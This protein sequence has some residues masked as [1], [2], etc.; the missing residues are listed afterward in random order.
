[1]EKF[2]KANPTKE[3]F[4]EMMT[5]DIE[6]EKAI[7][8][9]IDNCIDG[10]KQT[11]TL[12]DKKI[13]IN[14]SREKFSLYDNCGGF[15]VETAREYAFNFGRVSNKSKT[16]NQVDYSVG[17]FGIGMKRTL[18]KIG[19]NIKVESQTSN[20][21]FNVT[22]DIEDWKQKDEDWTFDMNVFEVD[23]ENM[24]TG[25]RIDVENLNE[26]IA[27]SFDE[28]NLANS[29]LLKQIGYSYA[30]VMKEGMEIYV[31]GELVP[32]KNL[33][34][35]VDDEIQPSCETFE[36]DGIEVKIIA[37][38][39]KSS[40]SEAG[41]YIYG[42]D[43]LLLMADKTNV[44]GWKDRTGGIPQYHATYAMFRGVVFMKAKD[45]NKLPLT[46]TKVGVDVDSQSYKTILYHMQLAMQP[47]FQFLSK[48]ED[49]EMRT[50]LYEDYEKISIL[51]VYKTFTREINYEFVTTIKLNEMEIDT[52]SVIRYKIS[53]KD[54]E[55]VKDRL[56]EKEIIIK[57]N[58]QLGEH[59]FK[60]FMNMEGI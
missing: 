50:E 43:R 14:I 60:Y 40:P 36:I 16:N 37:G 11:G 7:L 6:V 23:I 59:T 41:W 58:P 9:L 31:N 20:E 57:N 12:Y 19:K 55:K 27:C 30:P 29:T 34:I 25:T 56:R 18:F 17:R 48:I 53:K 8:D 32:A 51:E 42:N 49:R 24:W 52:E 28:E 5:K 2:V 35:I 47:I 38:I 1:M 39:S 44:T 13:E 33:D 4:I 21:H 45:V 54:I 3:F 10:A 26:D 46:T 15:S 22:I